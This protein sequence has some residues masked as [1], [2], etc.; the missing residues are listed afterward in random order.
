MN[1]SKPCHSNSDSLTKQKSALATLR[2]SISSDQALF[3][4]VY[5]HTFVCGREK[6]Q[7]ALSLENALVY[8]KILF[9]SAGMAWK[10]ENYNWL[11]LWCSFLEEKYKNSVSRDTWNQ[12]YEFFAKTLKD[13]NMEWYDDNGAWPVVLDEFAAYVKQ[14]STQEEM[15]LE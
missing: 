15:E 5:K 3:K 8:W 2:S 12:T 7:K 11:D 4:R 9:S 10:T 13:E 6:G 14:K 1:K